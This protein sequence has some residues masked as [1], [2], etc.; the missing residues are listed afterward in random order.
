[1]TYAAFGSA[2]PSPPP[3]PSPNFAPF[4]RDT[5]KAQTH[6]VGG[7]TRLQF[8]EVRFL[9]M[10]ETVDEEALYFFRQGLPA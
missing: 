2:G 1:M 9:R 7:E 5:R 8:H 4:F 6:N 10:A 3:D